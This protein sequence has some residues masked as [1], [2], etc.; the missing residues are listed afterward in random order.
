RLGTF[1]TAA[2]GKAVRSRAEISRG[3]LRADLEGDA[4]GQR[5]G[6]GVGLDATQWTVLGWRKT[7][8]DTVEPQGVPPAKS[9]PNDGGVDQ[10]TIP[11][12]AVRFGHASVFDRG[13]GACAPQCLVVGGDGGQPEAVDLPGDSV[14]S[15][16]GN[17]VQDAGQDQRSQVFL[18]PAFG[19]G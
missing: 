18:V 6:A 16:V 15:D 5:A 11:H 12:L 13:D 14:G 3:G 7:V 2:L 4:T 10:P 17:V 8:G 1:G 19:I 9:Q